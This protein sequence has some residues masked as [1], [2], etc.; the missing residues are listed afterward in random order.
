MAKK[1]SLMPHNNSIMM[2]LIAPGTLKTSRLLLEPLVA[3]HA[4]HI[5]REL[6][7]ERLYQ[8]IPQEPP[9]S[10][11]LLETR[12]SALSSRLSPDRQQAWLNWAVSLR[13]GRYIGTLEATVYANR[14]AAI[15]YMIF[16]SFWRQGYA[17]EGCL[18]LLNHLFNDYKVNLVAAEIDTR[19]VAS[20][21]LIKSLGFKR[22]STKENADFFKGCVSHEYRYECM[23]SFT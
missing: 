2:Q 13:G 4:V 14:T 17:K 1:L 18:Q 16:P 7:D 11:Q 9:T 22:V 21:E 5:Y 15:A 6:Q 10:L 12:Y 19:N 23:S 3:S 8:F 20:I